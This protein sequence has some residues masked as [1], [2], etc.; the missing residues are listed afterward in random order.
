MLK[1]K[2]DRI[3]KEDLVSLLGGILYFSQLWIYAHTTLSRLDESAYIYKGYLFATGVYRPFQPYGV[4]TNKAPFA[5]LIPGYIQAWFGPGLRPARYFGVLVGFLILLGVWYTARRLGGKI[6]GTA[7]VWLFV[8]TPALSKLYSP[9]LSQGL[10]A[11]MLVGVLALSLG[12]DRPVW[13]LSLSAAFA[14]LI[15]LTRQNMVLVLPILIIY[16]FWQYG[17]K[18]GLWAFFSG[19]IVVILGHLYW[20]P[21][22]MQLWAPWMPNKISLYLKSLY[23]MSENADVGVRHFF[24]YPASA[25]VLSLFRTFRFQLTTLI[26][27]MTSIFLW[28]GGVRNW[29]SKEKYRDSVFL[30]SLFLVLFA[31]HAWAS[32]GKN[33]CIYC[34]PSYFGFFSM[35]GIFLVVISASS[36]KKEIS[37]YFYPFLILLILVIMSGVG[38]SA[39]E[40]MGDTL[41]SLQVPRMKEGRILSGST[42]LM[43]LLSNKFQYRHNVASQYASTAAGFSVGVIF[44]I[45]VI[46]LQYTLL[47]K[48]NFNLGYLTIISFLIFSF[49]VSPLIIGNERKP[50]YYQNDIISSYE[51][52]GNYLAQYIPTGS[53]VYWKGSNSLLPLLYIPGGVEIY[54]SQLNAYNNYRIDGD[55]DTLLRL[56][57]WNAE[58][59]LQWKSEAEYIVVINYLYTGEWDTFLAPSQ[60]E[61]F[62]RSTT[63][64]ENNPNSFLR[65]FRRK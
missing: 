59:D 9:A 30:V 26:G 38:Y 48:K 60:F 32:L 57:F 14:G 23:N 25:R 27:V 47:R 37:K 42:D 29:K 54:P 13:Q 28:A 64:L 36:W 5:F 2:P 17:R 52:A 24:V 16:I 20:W 19:I 50:D 58:L 43:A 4:W 12:G 11:L 40:D 39:F 33:Y 35:S 6:W 31:M 41:L 56:G 46:T 51:E 44:L 61:E 63:L 45:T 18:A 53:T 21:E 62:P 8:F 7:V 55:P 22:I 10:I 15:V 34:L 1:K 49:T 3:E 65:I